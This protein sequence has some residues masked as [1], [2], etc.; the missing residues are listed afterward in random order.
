MKF[1]GIYFGFPHGNPIFATRS[2]IWVSPE[3]AKIDRKKDGAVAQSVEQRT[4]N[5]CVGGSIPP[6]TTKKIKR[7]RTKNVAAF[8]MWSGER[9]GDRRFYYF[10]G[11]LKPMKVSLKIINS[12][13][14][15]IAGDTKSAPYM[16]GPELVEFFNWYDFEDTYGAGFPSRWVYAAEKVKQANDSPRLQKIFEGFLDPRRFV[17]KEPL[18]EE[19]VKELNGLIIHDGYSAQ[20]VG[21]IYKI[22]SVQGGFIQSETA[23]ELGHNFI[24]EQITKC[25]EKIVNED[26]NGAIT[27]A[28]TLVEA[29]LIHVI[30]DVEEDVVKND[31]NINSGDGNPSYRL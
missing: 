9:S 8:F 2:K 7:L 1:S 30:E 10:R 3:A 18:L 19:C 4:E 23:T 15:L 26:Y 5:P 21:L 27:N 25:N 14:R 28:R 13:G 29:V 16:T 17:G 20:K 24:S 22:A 12:L 11:N 6:H 31:G